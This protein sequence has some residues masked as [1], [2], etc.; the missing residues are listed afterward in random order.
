MKD[1]EDLIIQDEAFAIIKDKKIY[2]KLEELILELRDEVV[3]I[4]NAKK[5][6]DIALKLMRKRKTGIVKNSILTFVYRNMLEQS[7][8]EA[9]L[10]LEN[11]LI[12]NPSRNISGVT[13]LTVL[14][15]PFPNGQKFS[16]EHDCF[17]CPQEPNQ[18]R[19]YLKKE[20]AVARA[21]DENFSPSGQINSRLNSLSMN[22]H[23]LDKVEIIIEGGTFT[24]Y[25]EE[26]LRDFICEMIYT[27]NTYWD[28]EKREMLSIHEEIMINAAA[29]IRIIGICSETRPDCIVK[30]GHRWLCLFRE[31][32]ITRVQIGVQHT[33]NKILKKINRGHKVEDSIDAIRILKDNCFKVDIHAMPDLPGSDPNKD[34]A[35]ISKIYHDS[36]FSPDQVKIYPCQVVPWTKIEKWFK[37]GSYV[38]YADSN[39]EKFC[40]VI[41]MSISNCPYHIRLPRVVRDIPNSYIEGGNQVTNL[42]QIIQNRIEKKGIAIKEIRHREC[43]RH[44]EYLVEEAKLFVEKIYCN[45]GIDYFI[46]YESSDRKALFGYLRLRI[47]S[48]YGDDEKIF[49]EL[50]GSALIREIHVYGRVISVGEAR[51]DNSAQHY[52]LGKRLI[53]KAESIAFEVHNMSKIS[54]IS[55]MGVVNYYKKLGYEVDFNFM[56]K[57][58]GYTSKNNII[59]RNFSYIFLLVLII[60]LGLLLP[61]FN[62][63]G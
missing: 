8:I 36:N 52:G 42:R 14:T 63:R 9:I 57:K 26:Y 24:E 50:V 58:K 56:S 40:D 49:N 7:K 18:P 44:P 32:G 39:F 28:K 22:G 17:Y 20:P 21:N 38:P 29:K 55:G 10:N 13:V 12:K 6:R 37:D 5:I 11:A 23:T 62:T 33:D 60:L 54:V 61:L 51:L 53:H 47:P 48:I 16:C 45:Q 15:A 25:P 41:E 34:I 30:Y 1:I 31:W 27:I 2:A 35:M 43:G 19:S 46:S 3:E 59:L 4:S